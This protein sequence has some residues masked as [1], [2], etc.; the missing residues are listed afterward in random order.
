MSAKVMAAFGEPDTVAGID[1]KDVSEDSVA[2][3][4]T[5]QH[6]QDMRYCH[7]NGKWFEWDGVRWLRDDAMRAFNFAREIGRRLSESHKSI[8]KSS[9][10]SGAEKFAR[11]DPA[12][13]VTGAIWDCNPWLMGT[14]GGILDLKAGALR[15][16]DPSAYITKL[17]GCSPS[18]DTPVLWLDFLRQATNGD[19][20]TIAYLQRVCGYLLTGATTE[21]ALFFIYGPGGNG[22]SVFLKLLEYV[23]G[24]YA[25]TAAMDTFTA[26]FG[27]KHPT[28]LAMLQGA[29]GVFAS[30]TEAGSHWAESRIKQMTGGDKISARFMRQDFFTFQPQFKLIIVGNHAP[31]VKNVDEA[32]RRRFNI[33]PFIN[34]PTRPDPML[35]DKLRAEAPAILGWML[36]GCLDWQERGLG[37]PA[38]IV[39]ATDT[40]FAEQDVFGQWL[41]DCCELGSTYT[42]TPT[43]LFRSWAEYA[44][45]N[46]EIAGSIKGFSNDLDKRGFK[47]LRT[48]Q[49][50]FFVGVRAKASDAETHWNNH[51]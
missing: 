46:G 42:E 27:N 17:T 35:E 26:S 33:I 31:S 15:K 47:R 11:A 38:A 22:K 49:G 25:A 48:A 29:R 21:H 44:K 30:E 13:A 36:Q 24:D 43:D 18:K 5:A 20:E 4:F 34:R 8:C 7:S 10:A 41:G 3:A 40:Y 28:D 9:V 50:R 1:P 16:P 37:R 23:L 19:I 6:R 12:H 51:D 2:L 45:A 14:P 39:A 32:L